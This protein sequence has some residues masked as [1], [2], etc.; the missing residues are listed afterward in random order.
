MTATNR[1]ERDSLGSLDVP[2]NALAR[3]PTLV[4]ALNPIIGYEKG[5]A[6]AGGIKGA[7]G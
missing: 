4:T 7:G 5:A 6:I 3:N 1:V 2:A